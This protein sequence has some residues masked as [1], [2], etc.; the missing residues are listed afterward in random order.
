ME[1][2]YISAGLVAE[3]FATNVHTL[4]HYKSVTPLCCPLVCDH[5]DDDNDGVCNSCDISPGEP[6]KKYCIWYQFKVPFTDTVLFSMID[7]SGNCDWSNTVITSNKT[8]PNAT[9]T[10]SWNGYLTPMKYEIDPPNCGGDDGNGQCK[11]DY[12]YDD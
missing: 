1:W 4:Y 12:D 5:K 6:D 10:S 3:S 11:C 8:V 9:N 7:R 2:P